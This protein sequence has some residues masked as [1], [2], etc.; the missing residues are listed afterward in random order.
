V[1]FLD[2]P[3]PHGHLEALLWDVPSPKAAAVVCHPHPL[4]G[5]TMHNHVTY[6]LA[7]ALRNAGIAALRFN[8]RGVGRSTG[9]HDEG[10]G[11][12]DDGRAALDF[13]AEHYP[14]LPLW[15][16]GFSFGSRVAL[17]LAVDDT[18]VERALVT[19]LALDSFDYDFVRTL[20]KPKAFIQADQ[21]EYAALSD[22]QAFVESLPPPRRLFVLERADHL[23]TGRLDAFAQVA[24]EA[25][26][27][28]LTA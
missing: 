12:V 23:A 9:Q 1:S 5:G 25:V 3:A 26:G 7:D 15:I 13:V 22:V 28:L 10:R 16:S 4:H 8:F 18:R 6:R 24:K 27:W 11:E 17:R 14:G 21:D 2:V 19:G 20:N